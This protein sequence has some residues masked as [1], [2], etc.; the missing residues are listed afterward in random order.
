MVS[1]RASLRSRRQSVAALRKQLTLAQ[2]SEI[3]GMYEGG[4]SLA[5]EIPYRTICRV[6]ANF[7]TRGTTSR[8]GRPRKSSHS[9][10]AHDIGHQT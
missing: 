5:M 2:R 8:S 6:V 3:A 1:T 10:E 9:E 7:Q 4:M